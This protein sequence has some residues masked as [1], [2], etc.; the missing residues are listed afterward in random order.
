MKARRVAKEYEAMVR[1]LN[2]ALVCVPPTGSIEEKKQVEKYYKRKPLTFAKT[3]VR[4]YG[5][6]VKRYPQSHSHQYAKL[7]VANIAQ[8][9]WNIYKNSFLLTLKIKLNVMVFR[10]M[11][12]MAFSPTLKCFHILI[13]VEIIK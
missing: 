11:T 12:P 4:V 2:K 6:K 9:A 7:T 10:D 5:H 3:T 8:N 1:G 13:F